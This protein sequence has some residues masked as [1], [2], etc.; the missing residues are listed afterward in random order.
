VDSRLAFGAVAALLGLAVFAGWRGMRP[1]DPRKGP[2]L[3]PWRWIMLLSV[4]AA[5]LVLI[6]VSAMMQAG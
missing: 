6:Q 3:M 5:L 2:R 1:W 4:T